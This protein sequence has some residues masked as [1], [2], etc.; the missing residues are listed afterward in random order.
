MVSTFLD[1]I[2]W[3]VI[4]SWKF[5]VET[6]EQ[7]FQRSIFIAT[8]THSCKRYCAKE[9]NEAM[10]EFAPL[11][12]KAVV[13]NSTGNI[14][15]GGEERICN[16]VSFLPDAREKKNKIGAIHDRITSSA[17]LLRSQFLEMPQFQW[18][19]S[20]ESDVILNKDTLPRLFDLT[21][22]YTDCRVFHT[23]C[24]KDFH[25]KYEHN[26]C[27]VDRMTMGC[28]LIHREVIEKIP[29]RY[30]PTLLKA[31]YDAVFAHDVRVNDYKIVYDA[32]IVLE[33]RENSTRGRGWLEL[34]RSEKG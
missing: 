17:N 7:D 9:F 11:C 19:L 32:G 31:H 22:M 26:P 33:H 3:R 10:A 34:P 28:A 21:I 13:F 23:E 1:E 30:D 24:Y 27:F 14:C 29:F 2:G 18:Y 25:P 16:R 12:Y 8:P 15:Y 4:Q 5:P 6:N 20:L